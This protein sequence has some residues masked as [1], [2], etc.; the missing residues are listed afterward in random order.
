VN[1]TG[2]AH[3]GDEV[4]QSQRGKSGDDSRDES[5]E[6]GAS[7]SETLKTIRKV[8]APNPVLMGKLCK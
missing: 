7:D 8:T 3:E 2:S 4:S 1:Q 6:K 5:E